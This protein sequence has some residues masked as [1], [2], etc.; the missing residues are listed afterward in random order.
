MLLSTPLRVS[1]T[2][3]DRGRGASPVLRTV[4][5]AVDM[6]Q[7]LVPTTWVEDF[8]Q[9]LD[10]ERDTCLSPVL[11]IRKPVQRGRAS[12]AKPHSWYMAEAGFQ[13]TPL[14]AGAGAPRRTPAALHRPSFPGAAQSG[15]PFPGSPFPTS[16]WGCPSLAG[17]AK[18]GSCLNSLPFSFCLPIRLPASFL[19]LKRSAALCPL[20]H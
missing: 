11:Q 12:C 18:L 17:L 8:I 9:T 10:P 19:L 6:Y 13:P 20:M 15:R 3:K 4:M 1:A 2:R 14:D 7:V 16:S 5:T